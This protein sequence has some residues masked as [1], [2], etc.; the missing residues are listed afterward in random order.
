MMF[1][2]H[3]LMYTDVYAKGNLED[4]RFTD[5][6]TPHYTFSLFNF[7]MRNGFLLV[8]NFNDFSSSC[9]KLHISGVI[10]IFEIIIIKRSC[11]FLWLITCARFYLNTV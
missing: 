10:I 9:F 11:Y 8:F 3:H 7:L 6:L 2:H 4:F 1:H 5:A